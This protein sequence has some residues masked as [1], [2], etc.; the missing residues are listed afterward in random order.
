MFMDWK[1]DG[2]L[3]SLT[4]MKIS[5]LVKEELFAQIVAHEQVGITGRR[6][7]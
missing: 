7:V 3:N 2:D 5:L 1:E 6:L 4:R